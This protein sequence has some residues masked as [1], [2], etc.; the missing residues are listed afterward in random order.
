MDA[1]TACFFVDVVDDVDGV[2]DV[3]VVIVDEI[4]V[5]VVE[6]FFTFGC[7]KMHCIAPERKGF[8]RNAYKY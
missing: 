5:F 7:Y 6:V 2:F 4:V 1:R 3:A 8:K